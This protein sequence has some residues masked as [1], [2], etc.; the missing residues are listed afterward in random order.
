M[1][2]T[3]M[4]VF[5][6]PK[7]KNL[8]QKRGQVTGIP[9]VKLLAMKFSPSCMKCPVKILKNTIKIGIPC[10]PL[11]TLPKTKQNL[12]TILY[13]SSV[14]KKHVGAGWTNYWQSPFFLLQL[15]F[16]SFIS[17]SFLFDFFF[18]F[19]AFDFSSVLKLFFLIYLFSSILI[20]FIVSLLLL[21]LLSLFFSSSS[22]LVLLFFSC[23]QSS[24]FSSSLL[25][26]IF[27][28]ALSL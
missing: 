14:K 9:V 4:P 24:S 21:F 2:S 17:F 7:L 16:G 25:F 18:L 19:F 10:R 12:H 15:F 11:Q 28:L 23:S 13:T 22:L 20:I 27:L 6:P 5:S 3:G 26:L 8:S 1:L